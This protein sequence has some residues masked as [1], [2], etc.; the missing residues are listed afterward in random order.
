M[1]ISIHPDLLNFVR[2]SAHSKFSPSASDRW[3]EEACSFSIKYCEN[4][5]E[6][7]SVYAAEGSLAHTIAEQYFYAWINGVPLAPEF[8]MQLLTETKDNG[9]EMLE[10]A[11]QYR[12][13]IA[14]YL[15]N[16]EL[17][18]DILY[19]GLERGIPIYPEEGAF[20]TA[21]V[22]IIGS[23]A[24][25]IGDYKFGRKPVHADSFQL[26][27]YAAGV[28]RYLFNL[29]D[30]YKFVAVIV[31]PRTDSTPKVHEYSIL[32]MD[33][34]L[35]KIWASIQASKRTDLSPNKGNWCHFCPANQ[36]K[37][38]DLQ[39][40][41]IKGKYQE[42]LDND[43]DKLLQA[44]HAPV[45]SFNGPNLSRDHAMLKLIAIAPYI[46]SLAANAKSELEYRI[47]EK[48]EVIAGVGIEE[49]LGNRKWAL[50]DEFQVAARI[51]M[52][53]PEVNPM[54]QPPLKLK[55]I[56]QIEKEVGKNKIDG[57]CIRPITK[58]V[59]LESETQK[60]ILGELA[61]LSQLAINNE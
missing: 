16:K 40:P 1:T 33:E 7:T 46:N 4:I 13:M 22:L 36:T 28:R 51:T 12:A 5:P 53:F 48:H 10:G 15:M 38:P 2:P 31:Q 20:G 50:D 30:D 17:I 49:K 18:G 32:E 19:Y 42:A 26:R 3:M 6:E 8:Q 47:L 54:I 11:E 9:A 29:P 59:V 35:N 14:F 57:M 56:T 25:I 21:D 41:L 45:Q 52:M 24:A 61:A 44:F 58:H 39:C 27:S 37:N 60:Q 43:F 23:K 55:T 34:T